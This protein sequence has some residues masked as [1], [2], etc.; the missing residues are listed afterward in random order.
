MNSLYASAVLLRSSD[1]SWQVQLYR[2]DGV[3]VAQVE[4]YEGILEA[5]EALVSLLCSQPS[6]TLFEHSTVLPD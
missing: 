4:G 6:T 5:T 1:D 3:C 2:W